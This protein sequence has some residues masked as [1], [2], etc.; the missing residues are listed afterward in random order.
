MALA[1]DGMAPRMIASVNRAGTPWG[2]LLLYVVIVLVLVTTNS[3]AKL[4]PL[5]RV[6]PGLPRHL[7]D[8]ELLRRPAQAARAAD[9]PVSPVG[10]AAVH[11]RQRGAVRA[12]GI[13]SPDG[14]LKAVGFLAAISLAYLVFRAVTAGSRGAA[15]AA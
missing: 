10:A 11:R 12:L 2:G 14:V 15:K 7:R 6:H 9:E 1:R 3:F 13:D 8:R 4:L 5:I